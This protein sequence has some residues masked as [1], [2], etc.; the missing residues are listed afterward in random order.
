[1]ADPT[2]GLKPVPL[3]QGRDGSELAK[4]AAC[5][6]KLRGA[7]RRY[8]EASASCAAAVLSVDISGPRNRFSSLDCCSYQALQ[9]QGA[10]SHPGSHR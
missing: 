1:M 4:A 10:S 6:G 7:G 2:G 3:V 5:L 9:L 8:M